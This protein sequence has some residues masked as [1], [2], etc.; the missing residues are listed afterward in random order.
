M[1]SNIKLRILFI[2]D[3]ETDQILA[4]REIKKAGI[5]FTSVRVETERDFIF[6]LENFDPNLIISDYSMPEFDGMS[7]LKIALKIKPDIPFLILTGSMNEETAVECMKAGADDYIIKENLHRL[8]PAINASLKKYENL[9]AKEIAEKSLLE[10]EQR[11]RS[12]FTES[13]AV[14]FLIDPETRRIIDANTAAEKFYGWTK[15]ELRKKKIEDINTLSLEEIKKEMQR[16][17][18][19]QR[20]HFEFKHRRAD[21]SV[22][23]VEVFSS[24]ID[25]RDKSQLHSIIHDI[26]ER[27]RAEAELISAKERA[28]KA[29]QLKTE[30]LAQMSH[31]IRT[32]L[33]AVLSFTDLIEDEVSDYVN[34]ELK[35]A[36][37]GVQ[38]ASKRIIRTIDSILNMSELHLGSY[39]LLIHE[40]NLV[41]LLKRLV[42]DFEIAAKAKNLELTFESS[43]EKLLIKSDDY[44]INQIIANLVDNA[45]KYTAEGTVTLKLYIKDNENYIIEVADTGIGI[46]EDYLPELFT[47]FS[48]EEQ[49]YSRK[50]DG[51]GLGMA[52]VKKYCDVI[53]G[54][55][56][57]ESKKNVG[58]KIMIQ[59]GDI[60]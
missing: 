57:I 43:A 33:N 39:E 30:F 1:E 47:P 54:Q 9:K 15:K 20:V 22:R 31:E 48:Q 35:V 6:Q 45:I 21:G 19:Q 11:F 42:K 17:V 44:A 23:D 38:S 32:P 37:D 34:E 53:G 36:F 60:N 24:K 52:L 8:I 58:T 51:T 18:A 2:E 28:E 13:L 29:D 14:M 12:L 50:Y 3:L 27:K 7:A 41:D 56:T 40:T 25:F 59:L 16:A 46:S 5:E 55:L 10:S 4:E 49:G 26:T